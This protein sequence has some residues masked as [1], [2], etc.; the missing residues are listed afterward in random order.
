MSEL[1][2]KYQKEIAP[3][4]TKEFGF[5]NVLAAPRVAKVVVS[6]GLG[7][8]A[9]D[10]GVIE[11][12]TQNLAMITGQKAKV[13][14]ARQSIAGFKLRAGDPIGVMTTL[15]NKRMYDF[16]EKLFKI[17]LPRVRDFQGLSCRSFDSRGNYSLGLKEQI[18]FPEIDYG[19]VVKIR[20][21]EITVVTNA[22]NDEKAKRLL[23]LMGMPFGKV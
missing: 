2:Q 3:K 6:I 16:L 15:R 14:R 10:K 18:V 9:Q 21:L 4:L 17:V 22:K 12:A 13:T 11:T 8:G 19:K 20:G 5:K 1:K 23:E 7:E